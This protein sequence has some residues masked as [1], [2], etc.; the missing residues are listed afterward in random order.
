MYVAQE[1]A[2]QI[3]YRSADPYQSIDVSG[4]KEDLNMYG[5]EYNY[6]TT[7][8]SVGCEYACHP[9]LIPCTRAH[10]LLIPRTHPHR[11]YLFDPL[12]NRHHLLPSQPLAA[13]FGDRVSACFLWPKK[14]THPSL[15]T[16][17]YPLSLLLLLAGAS[18][19]G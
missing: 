2:P 5:N 11:L 15:N 8:F 1:M 14:E 3:K 9:V 17:A 6:F 12:S 18:S 16:N 7:Y 10:S 13:V 4:M 19:P